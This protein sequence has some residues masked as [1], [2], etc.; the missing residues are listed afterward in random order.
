MKTVGEVAELAGVTVRTL[1]HYDELGLL[2]PSERSGAGYRLYS[3]GDLERLQEILIW[4]QLGFSLVAIVSLLDDPG[5]DRL[6]AL[7][8][9]RELVGR[10]IDR[11][12][13]LAAAVDAAIDAQKNGTAIEE[14]RMFEGFDPTEYEDEV[15]ERWGDTDAYRESGRRTR[16]Y[17]E[18]EWGSIRSEAQAIVRELATLMRAGEPADGAEARALAERHREHISRWFYPCSPQVHRGLGELYIADERFTRT[19]ERE[20]PGLAQYFHDAIAAGADAAD[21]DERAP[22]SR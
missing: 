22:V 20:A 13:A 16:S 8:R 1:H 5:H 18:A 11:L 9:Q 21:S 2:S 12:G 7:E 17:G 19:Y 15:R 10:E 3:H 4:R 6:A 14:A